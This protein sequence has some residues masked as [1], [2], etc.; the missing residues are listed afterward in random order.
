MAN[1]LTDEFE[2]EK[3]LRRKAR[4][5]NY[6]IPSWFERLNQER[7]EKYTNHPGGMEGKQTFRL[8]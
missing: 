6:P 5:L 1:Q 7:V 2:L 3:I 8:R 4:I